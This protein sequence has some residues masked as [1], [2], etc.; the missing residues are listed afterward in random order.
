MRNQRNKKSWVVAVLLI[1]S[2]IL[3]AYGPALAETE[4]ESEVQGTENGGQASVVSGTVSE[5]AEP[6]PVVSS[7]E[8]EA[9][10]DLSQEDSDLSITA[11][12]AVLIDART[13]TVLYEK[14]AHKSLPMASVTKVM[15][16]LLVMEAVDNGSISLED[17]VTISNRAAEMGGSQLFMEP[18]EQHTVAELMK[19]VAMASAND[20]CVAFHFKSIRERNIP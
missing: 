9:T 18:G 5:E 2:L 19:G 3:M 17:Q 7:G 13:G 4:K 10:S 20:G 1:G 16:M 6:R 15:S 12:G 11:K 8:E 14:N